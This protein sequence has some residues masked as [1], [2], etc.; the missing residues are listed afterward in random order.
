MQETV[1]IQ[2]V[3]K[4]GKRDEFPVEGWRYDALFVGGIYLLG[5]ATSQANA[6]PALA[7]PADVLLLVGFVLLAALLLVAALR[8]R[9]QG[10]AWR[11]SLPRGYRLS[12]SGALLFLIG[13]AGTQLWSALAGSPT[14]LETLLLPTTLLALIGALLL[15][16]G[17]LLAAWQRFPVGA[18]RIEVAVYNSWRGLRDGILP[19]PGM[20]KLG[21]KRAER[22]DAG[23]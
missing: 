3:D 9:R 2:P 6:L 23:K 21:Q 11:R 14:A 10:Y 1:N 15:V 12:L 16:G 8:S 7:S 22:E 17:P 13:L 19:R 4:T 20:S 5:R 18:H